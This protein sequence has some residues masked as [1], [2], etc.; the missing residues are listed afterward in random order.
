MTVPQ[1]VTVGVE[2]ADAP[3]TTIECP[4]RAGQFVCAVPA[5]RLDLRVAPPGVA[6]RYIWGIDVAAGATADLGELRFERGGSIVGSVRFDGDGPP[7]QNVVV[8]LEP[9]GLKARPN[10]RG[11]FQFTH[12]EPGEY[13]IIARH[14]GWSSAREVEIRVADGRE[15]AL[16]RPLIIDRWRAST[17]CC[18][19]SSIHMASRGKWRC[20]G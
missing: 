2:S 18:S 19:H 3:P 11:F 7:V 14:D 1:S 10:A 17:C 9:G 20:V 12:L 15:T 8:G 13:A 16:T 6:P 4:V 5:S